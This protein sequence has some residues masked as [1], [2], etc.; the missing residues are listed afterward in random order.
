MNRTHDHHNVEHAN[1]TCNNAD[2]MDPVSHL[3]AHLHNK[4]SSNECVK[5]TL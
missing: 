4:G 1:Q 2:E 3:E 5:P